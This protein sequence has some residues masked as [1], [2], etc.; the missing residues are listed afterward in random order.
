MDILERG[1][2][3]ITNRE[4]TFIPNKM[5]IFLDRQSISRIV[6]NRGFT[7]CQKLFTCYFSF[8]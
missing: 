2:N 3:D 1:K 4:W 6:A 7:G 8:M 5:G